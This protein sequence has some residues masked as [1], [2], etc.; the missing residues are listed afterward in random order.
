MSMNRRMRRARERGKN[1]PAVDLPVTQ[2]RV[3]PRSGLAARFTG[4]NPRKGLIH[5]ITANDQKG[6]PGACMPPS[7]LGLSVPMRTGK[8]GQV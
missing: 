6:R 8:G 3:S 1:V 5:C 2:A 4:S 7:F